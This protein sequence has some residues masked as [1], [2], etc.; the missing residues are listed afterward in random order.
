MTETS[1]E[2]RPTDPPSENVFEDFQDNYL[3]VRCGYTTTSDMVVGSEFVEAAKKTSPR[4]VNDLAVADNIR[5]LV[6]FPS[7]VNIQEKGIIYPD[8]TPKEWKWVVAPYRLLTEEEK[9]AY[10]SSSESSD[11]KWRLAVEHSATFDPLDFQNAI[12]FLGAL[13]ER[14]PND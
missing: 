3:C 2:C 6:W 4:L 13:V 12:A 7:V 11:Y 14:I 8:G 5:D 10:L 1:I 9:T